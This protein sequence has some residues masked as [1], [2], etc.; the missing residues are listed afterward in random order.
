VTTFCAKALATLAT[1]SLFREN[2]HLAFCAEGDDI[3]I[4]YRDDQAVAIA[5]GAWDGGDIFSEDET[6]IKANSSPSFYLSLASR[7][8]ERELRAA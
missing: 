7:A 5:A 6:T 8:I 2:R 1:E 3:F 4:I